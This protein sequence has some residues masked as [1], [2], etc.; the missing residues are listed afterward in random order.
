MVTEAAK[1][2]EADAMRQTYTP[3]HRRLVVSPEN[4]RAM[5]TEFIK[6]AQQE[7]LIYD[8]QVSDNAIQKVLQ[9]RAKAGVQIRI[10]GGLEKSLT[11]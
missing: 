11:G 9:E 7:L 8:A 4:S 6:G 10:I 5:L 1:L 2:F 3:T